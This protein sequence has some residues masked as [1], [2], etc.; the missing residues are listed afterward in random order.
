MMTILGGLLWVLAATPVAKPQQ[1][2][3]AALKA[4]KTGD[5]KTRKDAYATLWKRGV[6]VAIPRAAQKAESPEPFALQGP[7]VLACPNPLWALWSEYADEGNGGG[8]EREVIGF[9][10]SQDEFPDID[11]A[12][13]SEV[14][15]GAVIPLRVGGWES[16][17]DCDPG[18]DMSTL[19]QARH[20][21]LQKLLEA[22]CG[23]N[24]ECL[25][26]GTLDD[27]T[28]CEAVAQVLESASAPG[29]ARKDAAFQSRVRACLPAGERGLRPDQ[30]CAYADSP[31][32][33][34]YRKC[35]EKVARASFARGTEAP[36]P[37][38]QVWVQASTAACSLKHNH[39]RACTL[40]VVDP[41]Q[42]RVGYRCS[43]EVIQELQVP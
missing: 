35:V 19:L 6:R 26:R 12:A 16:T 13:R 37:E 21:A 28:R 39:A 18:F 23:E 22:C 3:D 34:R 1:E 17:R 41:C 7:G 31:L 15:E 5:E 24:P 2:I 27:G 40:I 33:S 43:D 8:Y 11:E 29:P 14:P 9:S 42:G 20:P 10:R 25:Q 30:L 4:V 36:D 32:C 38:F